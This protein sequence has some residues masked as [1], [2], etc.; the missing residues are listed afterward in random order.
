MIERKPD[1]RIAKTQKAL[2]TALMQL[3]VERGYDAVTVQDIVDRA[4]VSRTTFYLHYRDK[5][6]LLEKGLFALFDELQNNVPVVTRAQFLAD[7]SAYFFESPDDF[8]HVADNAD[9]YR[10][11]LNEQ[12]SAGF[13]K[14]VTEYLANAIE[15]TTYRP[16]AG[17]GDDAPK[18]PLELMSIFAAGGEIALMRWW[19]NHDLPYSAQQMC[20]IM[21][22]LCSEGAMALLK[23]T[24]HAKPISDA[25]R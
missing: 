20:D 14:A 5:A 3:I 1:R 10:V 15:C 17:S 24:P 11:M 7:P 22:A 21:L 2:R 6:E 25:T 9:F 13:I 12:G 18:I 4:D 8:Q 19:L 23:L 16:L